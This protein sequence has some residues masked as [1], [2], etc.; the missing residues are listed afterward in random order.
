MDTKTF[1]NEDS[2]WEC[3]ISAHWGCERAS[4]AYYTLERLRVKGRWAEGY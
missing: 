1:R 2:T 4:P 3:K